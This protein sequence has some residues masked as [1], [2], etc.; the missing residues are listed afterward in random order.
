MIRL[1]WVSEKK[2]KKSAKK[3]IHKKTYAVNNISRERKPTA[4]RK[5]KASRSCGEGMRAQL[6]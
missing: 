1:Q 5:A 2:I 3:G 4:R 6:I